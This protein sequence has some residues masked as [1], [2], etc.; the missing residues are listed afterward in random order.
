MNKIRVKRVAI[1]LGVLIPIITFPMWAQ[2]L[3]PQMFSTEV[4]VGQEPNGTIVQARGI[5][6][7]TDEL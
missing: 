2:Y 5:A 7:R 3:W 6:C 4:C 1:A